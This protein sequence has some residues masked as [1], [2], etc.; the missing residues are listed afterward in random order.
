MKEH[1]LTNATNEELIRRFLYDSCPI[2]RELARRLQVN[3]DRVFELK[4]YLNSKY[5]KFKD[6]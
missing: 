3:T 4:M 5:G 6:K 2:K 1:E